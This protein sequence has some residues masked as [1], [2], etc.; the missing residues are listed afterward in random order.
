MSQEN[1]ELVRGAF[2]AYIDH[3]GVDAV[4]DYYAE[5]CVVEDFPEMPDRATYAGKEGVRERDRHFGEI[6]GDWVL[7][8]VELIDGGDDVVIA[9][10]AMTGRGRGSGAPLDAV[11]VFV[12]ELRDG[13]IVRDRAFTS[14]AEAL[15][16]V[17]L[18]E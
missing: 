12:V 2:A 8:P 4:L 6:W 11:A 9:V 1:V 16:A 18:R 10:V 3:G 13:K 14:K 5:D 17:G 15:E 7:D